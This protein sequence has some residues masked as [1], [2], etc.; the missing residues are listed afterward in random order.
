MLIFV[1]LWCE[2]L[3]VDRFVFVL[4]VSFQSRGV[5]KLSILLMTE[6]PG[7]SLKLLEHVTVKLP[8]HL[9]SHIQLIGYSI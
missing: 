5:E 3:I 9:K 7:L 1:K 6:D 2:N 4:F 8:T